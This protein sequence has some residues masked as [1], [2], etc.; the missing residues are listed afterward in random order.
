MITLTLDTSNANIA[1]CIAKGSEILYNY[2]ENNMR[3]QAEKI[4]PLLLEALASIN[5]TA[6]DIQKIIIVTGPGGFSGI[7]TGLAFVKGFALVHNITV[8]G[9]SSLQALAFSH[10]GEYAILA[11]YNAGKGQ[12]YTQF[13]D[14]NANIMTHADCIFPEQLSEFLIEPYYII[15]GHGAEIA[16]NYVQGS[17]STQSVDAA[18]LHLALHELPITH[19][20]FLP[21]KAFYIR[22]PDADLPKKKFNLRA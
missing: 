13:F 22:P 11:V 8:L 21:V 18:K 7:R 3:G 15:C 16:Q 5:L 1:L 14:K 12:L 6:K 4:A 17:I 2:I 9:I 19:P 10:L 20:T